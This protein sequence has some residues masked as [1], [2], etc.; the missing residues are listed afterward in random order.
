[1]NNKQ[2]QEEQE[3]VSA[4]GVPFLLDEKNKK[5]LV[6]II[7]PSNNYGGYLWTFPK[8]KI[9]DSDSS[10]EEAALREVRE[11]AGIIGSIVSYLGAY[12]GTH[13]VTH[14]YSMKIV[15]QGLGTDFETS[16]VKLVTVSEAHKLLNSERDR[17]VLKDF[18]SSLMIS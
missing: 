13:T 1:M 4:G 18:V 12:R 5:L 16:D 14:Y 10:K 17:K 7:K 15:Q 3:W 8:G 9:D 2:E 11:E 6:C